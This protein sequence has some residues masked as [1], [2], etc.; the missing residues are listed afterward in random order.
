MALWEAGPDV[1]PQIP[2]GVEDWL[3]GLVSLR[4]IETNIAAADRLL[5]EAVMGM[6]FKA[7]VQLAEREGQK[8]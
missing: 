5:M 6:D 8:G 1:N 7:I 2:A 3:C 4:D